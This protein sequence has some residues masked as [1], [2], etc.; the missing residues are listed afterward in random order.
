MASWATVTR[1]SAGPGGRAAGSRS[2]PPPRDAQHEAH[3]EEREL[4]GGH[5][6][7][8]ASVVIPSSDGTMAASVAATSA[9][10]N[11]GRVPRAGGSLCAAEDAD[12][13][14]PGVGDHRRSAPSAPEPDNP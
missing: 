14:F 1:T 9:S 8:I 6:I 12:G 4:G 10:V 7:G 3:G 2:G 13:K 5:E 11:F